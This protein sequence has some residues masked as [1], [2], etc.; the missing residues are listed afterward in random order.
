LSGCKLVAKIVI[1]AG[2]P[3]FLTVVF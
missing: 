3:Y 2:M 1:T